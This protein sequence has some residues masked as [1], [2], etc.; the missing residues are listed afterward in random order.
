MLL[1][2]KG[3]Y[4]ER[5]WIKFVLHLFQASVWLRKSVS[6]RN[7]LSTTI[8]LEGPSGLVANTFTFYV[9]AV[10]GRVVSMLKN[11][12]LDHVD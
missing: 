1:K 10:A 7:Q 6:S 4:S 11:Q 3:L 8:H 2:P 5:L 12:H 9:L